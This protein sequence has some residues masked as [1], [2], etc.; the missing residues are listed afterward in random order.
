M[1]VITVLFLTRP[2]YSEKDVFHITRFIP[3][4]LWV[5]PCLWSLLEFLGKL[6]EMVGG[7]MFNTGDKKVNDSL[8]THIGMTGGEGLRKGVAWQANIWY[9]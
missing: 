4:F 5:M 1:W 8:G 2:I 6:E 3:D 7:R 9:I